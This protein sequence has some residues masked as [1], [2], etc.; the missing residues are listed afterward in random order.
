MYQYVHSYTHMI[1]ETSNVSNCFKLAE[2]FIGP[3]RD[4]YIHVYTLLYVISMI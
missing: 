3:G 2:W 4:K 1:L